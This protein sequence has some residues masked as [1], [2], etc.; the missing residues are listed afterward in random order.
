MISMIG[1][2]A[3]VAMGDKALA[4]GVGTGEDARLG[5]TLKDPVGDTGQMFRMHLSGAMYMNWLPLMEQK[6]DS[7]AAATAPLS[8]SEEPSLDDADREDPHA[9]A[10]QGTGRGAR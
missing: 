6:I 2:P 10:H 4:L 1:Q 3:W 9:G 5:D 7:L 8:K